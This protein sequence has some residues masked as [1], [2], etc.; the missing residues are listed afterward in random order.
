MPTTDDT[1]LTSQGA[2]PPAGTGG[3]QDNTSPSGD[4]DLQFPDASATSASS[5][6][7]NLNLTENASA[8]TSDTT[9]NEINL[10]IDTSKQNTTDSTDNFS[11]DFS[12]F[13]PPATPSE[14]PATQQTEL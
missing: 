14:T 10:G 4:F 2:N 13:A 8:P 5:D 11:L 12:D 1:L 3:T 9:T 7:F 6:D